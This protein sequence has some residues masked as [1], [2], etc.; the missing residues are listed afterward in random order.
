VRATRKGP[1]GVSGHDTT[2]IVTWGNTRP[3]CPE[4]LFN[5][6]ALRGRGATEGVGQVPEETR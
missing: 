6:V 4:T 5:V 2:S 3:G 1:L